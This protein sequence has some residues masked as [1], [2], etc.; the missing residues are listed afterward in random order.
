MSAFSIS[1][2]FFSALML[3]GCVTGSKGHPAP[4]VHFL[5]T[6]SNLTWISGPENWHVKQISEVVVV[7]VVIRC[8]CEHEYATFSKIGCNFFTCWFSG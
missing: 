2:S 8:V 7:P 3:A 1:V 4:K 5:G 6:W